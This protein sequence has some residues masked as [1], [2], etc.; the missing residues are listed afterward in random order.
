MRLKKGVLIQKLGDTFVAYDNDA[1]V[2][3][4]LNEVAYIILSEIEKRKGKKEILLK[5]MK[6]FSVSEKEAKKDLDEF[7][8]DLKKVDLIVEKK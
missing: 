5:I 7:V 3:H 4:E 6:A 2:M 8:Q 1:S